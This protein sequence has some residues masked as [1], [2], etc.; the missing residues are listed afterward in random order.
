MLRRCLFALL[1]VGFTVPARG[2]EAAEDAAAPLDVTVT[3]QPT[4]RAA[5]KGRASSRVDRRDMD[6]RLP[7]SAPDALRYEPGV[8]VQQSAHGQGSPFLRGRTGQQTVI[9]FDGIRMN[10]SLYRQGPNQYF[11]TLDARTIRQIEVTRGGASTRYGSDAMGGV[12]DAR[13]IEPALEPAAKLPIVRPRASS[14]FATADTDFGHR[15]QIDAQL[16]PNVRFLGGA[17]HRIAGRLESGGPVRSPRTGQIP[18]VPAFERDGRTQLGTGYREITGD[19]RLVLGLGSGRRLV[20]AAYIYRQYDSP[21]T[22]QCPPP[23]APRS[24]CLDYDEQFRSLVYVALEGDMG[25]IARFGRVALSYQRQHERRIFDRPESFIQNIGRDSVDTLGVTMKVTGHEARLGK[26]MKVRVDGGADAYVD[27]VT[28]RAWTTFSDIDAVL[29][30]SR[31]QYVDGARYVQ[32]GA[33]IEG[34]VAIG[35]R[36]VVR[37]GGRGALARASAGADPASGTRA[38]SGTWPIAVGHVGAEY[39]VA[40][41]ITLVALVDRSYR[42]PNLDDLTSRQQ[43][44][45]GFQFENPDL[46]PEKALTFEGGIKLGGARFEADVWGFYAG[47]DDAIARSLRTIA[48]CPPET[49]QCKTSWS[50]FQLV[51]TA[52]ASFITGVEVS[53]RAALLFGIS[54]R[55]TFAYAYG[56]A[57]NPQPRPADPGLDYEPRVPISRI[58]PLNGSAELRWS[59][60]RGLWA[61]AAMRWAALQDRLA[62]TDFT[63]ARIPEGGTP[64]FVVLDLRAGYRILRNLSIAAVVENV[65]D[66]AYR[67]HGSSVNGA[68]RGLIVNVEAG[69]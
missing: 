28:S 42:A 49:P 8:F 68:G 63:D 23:F 22:D 13:P 61:G 29:A 64:G 2:A 4:D 54:A 7:R 9:L 57:P 1:V 11:F 67:H 50:R 56:S 43:S 51:N 19:G 55:A 20:A 16:R 60:E 5:A 39:R 26:A 41:A 25:R 46:E 52:G 34:E 15:F 37:A 17:G 14:R 66:T 69:L 62:P 45:P 6:E 38:V 32:G 58:P 31:G 47:V 53:A 12:L 59:S 27:L 33:F 24:E 3:G 65:T 35:E 40:E 44:G 18:Q 21:R 10:T 36:L 48:D 30:L